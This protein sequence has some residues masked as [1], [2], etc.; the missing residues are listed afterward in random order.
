MK[1][2]KI[3]YYSNKYKGLVERFNQWVRVDDCVDIMENIEGH[4]VA[5]Y[6]IILHDLRT[7]ST[8]FK[9]YYPEEFRKYKVKFVSMGK[10]C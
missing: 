3:F 9:R 4:D 2:E 8:Y 5:N 6:M 7:I 10:G 1:Q